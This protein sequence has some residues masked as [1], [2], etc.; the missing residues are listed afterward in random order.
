MTTL[1]GPARPQQP[2]WSE[3]QVPRHVGTAIAAAVG[4]AFAALALAAVLVYLTSAL[5]AGGVV[6]AAIAAL[7]PFVIVIAV[8]RWID[9]WEP[10][11]R[12]ALVFAVLWGA[13]VA[14]AIA[15]LFD[16][17]VQLVTNTEGTTPNPALQ[18]IVQAPLVEESA[19]GLGVLL[20]LWFNRRNFDGPV[21]GIVYAAAVAAGFAFSEN[22]L[23][24]GR[25]VV[26]HGVGADFA[27]I[28][29]ARGLFSPFA[30]ALFT[31][32]T[33]FA[34]GLGAGRGS[35]LG[36]LGWFVAGVIP[37]ACLH[38]LWNGGLSASRSTI[39]YYFTVEVPIFL[40]A[41]ALVLTVRV[42]ERRITRA[43]LGEYAQ[44]GWF[45]ADEVALLSTWTGR[46]H[47]LRW[48]DLQPDRR[49]KRK[50]MVRFVRDATRLGHARQRL[51]K[52]RRGVGRTPD[53]QE[54]LARITA[55]RAVLTS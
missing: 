41:T 25:T 15:L 27:V 20:L 12:A 45:T 1:A 55:D 17:G 43:R 19:K 16:L 26:E 4:I 40:L 38:A 32:C 42:R 23:Y 7:V 11:P 51:L 2:I 50:A 29:I 49:R 9:R 14:V 47:A 37:A 31:A 6:I 24:F 21:D 8:V 34:L 35:R 44:A 54:L 46:R 10:E 30:H 39:G 13:G 18:A 28:F 53:E 22:I 3:P 33:G 5:G 36:S 52:A 48:A